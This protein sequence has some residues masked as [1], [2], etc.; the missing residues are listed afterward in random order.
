MLLQTH[1][2]LFLPVST[3]LK[4]LQT[5]MTLAVDFLC[6]ITVHRLTPS[7]VEFPTCV[8]GQLGN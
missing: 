8:K 2:Y 6:K 7:E 1:F 4:L 5:S 3:K